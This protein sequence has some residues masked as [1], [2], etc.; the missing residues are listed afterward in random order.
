MTASTPIYVLILIL[1]LQTV[2]GDRVREGA[3]YESSD[4]SADIK[5][6]RHQAFATRSATAQHSIDNVVK[7][8]APVVALNSLNS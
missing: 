3:A 8:S 5:N 4:L 2:F 1:G 6:S 7:V